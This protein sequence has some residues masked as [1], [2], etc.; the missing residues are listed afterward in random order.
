[1]LHERQQVVIQILIETL[2][3]LEGEADFVREDFRT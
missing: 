1:M 3:Q 2:V